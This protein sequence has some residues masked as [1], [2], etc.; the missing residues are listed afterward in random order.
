MSSLHELNRQHDPYT[1]LS[2]SPHPS[3][4]TNLLLHYTGCIPIASRPSF[5]AS[6][7]PNQQGRIQSYEHRIA[8]LRAR[9]DLHP[10]TSAAGPLLQNFK[11]LLREYKLSQGRPVDAASWGGG[12]DAAAAWGG[13]DSV[14]PETAYFEVEDQLSENG[15]SGG[16][17]CVEDDIKAPV[18]F[19]R[20]RRPCTDERLEGQFPRQKVTVRELLSEDAVKNPLMWEPEG[21]EIRYIHLPANNMI[22][23]E[24]AIARYYGE[25]RPEPT[26]LFLSSKLKRSRTKTEMLLRQEF[27]HGQQSQ[28]ASC[29]VHARNMRGMCDSISIGA[30]APG[31]FLGRPDD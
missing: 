13:R 22:W 15:R 16:A 18:V 2:S 6:L 4:I 30:L 24:E 21:D 5:F 23:V 9:L 7:P 3:H 8:H 29:E 20:N 11:A 31:L 14:P 17:A 27:W 28:D 10:H 12:R 1:C 19:F 26:D 25:K